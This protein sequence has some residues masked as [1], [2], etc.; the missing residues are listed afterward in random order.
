LKYNPHS[1]RFLHVSFHTHLDTVDEAA[2]GK[3]VTPFRF[4]FSAD[5]WAPLADAR[6]KPFCKGDSKCQPD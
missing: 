3:P 6:E 2:N 5:R 1:E 4:L